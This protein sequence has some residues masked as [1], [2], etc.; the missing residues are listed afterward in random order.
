[1]TITMVTSTNM[2]D[3][4]KIRMQKTK[5]RNKILRLNF[6]SAVV[7]YHS[8]VMHLVEPGVGIAS[9]RY[10]HGIMQSADSKLR[11]VSHVYENARSI[12][13]EPSIVIR[14]DAALWGQEIDWSG[15]SAKRYIVQ[16]SARQA[17]PCDCRGSRACCTIA[18][19]R[20][21]PNSTELGIAIC[22]EHEHRWFCLAF[23]DPGGDFVTIT[24]HVLW[25][26]EYLDSLQSL[27]DT[28]DTND[29]PEYPSFT[30]TKDG[31][32]WWWFRKDASI[33]GTATHI[34]RR[35]WR[36]VQD[37]QLAVRSQGR[38]RHKAFACQYTSIGD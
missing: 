12:P 15:G 29:W 33:A 17:L 16:R 6:C 25:A 38:S 37:Y 32:C 21:E 14:P 8:A 30:T 22:W 35:P 1:M 20:A 13:S 9:P 18:A 3:P 27:Q 5:S 11:L 34:C 7:S 10:I 23:P 19:S 2:T 4:S 24:W 28:H 31:L 36:I 26:R